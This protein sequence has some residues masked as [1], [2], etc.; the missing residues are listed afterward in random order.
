M[1]CHVLTMKSPYTC[2]FQ[3]PPVLT[4]L[5]V[6]GCSCFPLLKPYNTLKFQS[7]T[8]QCIFL[9][10]AGQYKGYIC[11]NPITNKFHVSRHVLFDENTYPYLDLISKSYV[12][13]SLR[14]PSLIVPPSV[15]LHNV[16]ESHTSSS[17]QS[18]STSVHSTPK[19]SEFSSINPS[20]SES[21]A[22]LTTA[23]KSLTSSSTNLIPLLQPVITP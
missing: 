9:G 20:A 18:S 1:P 12:T 14:M 16:I 22:Y 17:S 4:D 8:T 11:F 23:P 13:Q 15:T 2:L 19:A 3:K 5:K 7:K 10:Y 21:L 6:F